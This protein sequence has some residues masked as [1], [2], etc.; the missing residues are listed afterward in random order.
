MSAEQEHILVIGAGTSG[1]AL[2]ARL[3]EDPRRHV[4]L[5]EAGPDESA[6]GD[7]VLDPSLAP[8]AWK[9][10][11][12][13]AQTT[14]RSEHG[15]I[16]V[17]QARMM[18]GMSAANGLATLRGLPVDYDGWAASGLDGWGWIDVVETFKSLETDRD[19]GATNLHGG[20]GP[21]SVR[22]WRRDEM[23]HAQI[24]FQDGMAEAANPVVHDINDPAQL[25]GIGVFPVT[26]D[27]H[28][29]RLTTSLAFLTPSVRERSNL[30]IRTGAEAVRIL[31]EGSRACGV[32]LKTGEELLADEVI[33]SAGALWSPLLL[34]RS[35]VGPAAHL[36]EH[37]I[38]LRVDLPVGESLS[39]HLGPGLFYRH[40]GPRG[41]T[42]GP[43]QSLFIGASDGANPD[44]HLFPIAR[45]PADAGEDGPTLFMMAAFLMRSS[46]Q[47]TVRLGEN[48]TAGPVVTAPPLPDNG[49]DVLRHAFAKLAEWE[50]T[51]AF[52]RSGCEQV[53]P[54]DLRSEEAVSTA[55]A[56]AFVSYGHMTSSCPMGRVL[57]A[58]CRVLGVEGLRV[59]DAS[60]M[61]TI[62][63]GNTYLGCVMT[64][65]RVSQKMRA[66]LPA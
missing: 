33:I 46:G 11:G 63:A 2:A 9:G 59:V 62:P 35:G 53:A 20:D 57:D 42:A 52:K 44:Y 61:P 12:P 29:Q 45:T 6:Y 30:T 32:K 56:R 8:D 34:M 3:S 40:Q 1:S 23:S 5:L 36:A 64:A 26:V 19:F 65:E 22:R 48:E 17:F 27:A 13:I 39:D 50:E 51:E 66:A 15:D 38:K 14:M 25:P 47:G 10:A 31:F 24:A 4:T 18:G 28:G 58:E 21:L 41:G 37:G 55:L 7:Y 54:L 49:R 16:S 43:A 60:S